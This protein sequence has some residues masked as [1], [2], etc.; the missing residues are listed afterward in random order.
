M[1]EPSPICRCHDCGAQFIERPDLRCPNCG[2]S[3]DMIETLPTCEVCGKIGTAVDPIIHKP[4]GVDAHPGCKPPAPE[5]S[6]ARTGRRAHQG[7]HRAA[8]KPMLD[9][10]TIALAMVVRG[11]WGRP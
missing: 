7:Q 6:G 10:L 1:N 11:V 2:A 3:R 5:R 8:R 4:G 9:P